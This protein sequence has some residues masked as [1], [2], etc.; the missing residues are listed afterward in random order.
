MIQDIE[1]TSE[2]IKYYCDSHGFDG[3][4]I[5]LSGG[6][7]SAVSMSL[8]VKSMGSKFESCFPGKYDK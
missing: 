6:I 2:W 1:K 3:C 5:G 7:D 8:A 4:V